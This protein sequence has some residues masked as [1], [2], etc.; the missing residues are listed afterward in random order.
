MSGECHDTPT[1]SCPPGGL[2]H[3]SV[4][5]IVSASKVS[6]CCRDQVDQGEQGVLGGAAAAL[7]LPVVTSTAIVPLTVLQAPCQLGVMEQLP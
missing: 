4:L 5:C 7:R 1:T 2:H 3:E 6:M